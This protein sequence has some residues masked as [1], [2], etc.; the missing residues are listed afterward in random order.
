MAHSNAAAFISEIEDDRISVVSASTSIWGGIDA[1]PINTLRASRKA[2]NVLRRQL[3]SEHARVKSLDVEDFKDE[4]PDVDELRYKFGTEILRHINLARQTAAESQEKA[5]FILPKVA[6]SVATFKEIWDKTSYFGQAAAYPRIDIPTTAEITRPIAEHVAGDKRPRDDLSLS[7]TVMAPGGS[8]GTPRASSPMDPEE[9]EVVEP[10]AMGVDGFRRPGIP[11]RRQRPATPTG[12]ASQALA[13]L[14]AAQPAAQS[15]AQQ[16]ALPVAPTV[17]R[18]V[19][20]WVEQS[21]AATASGGEQ[22]GSAEDP[23]MVESPSRA[24]QL[25]SAQQAQLEEM[26]RQV[27]TVEASL[28]RQY[29]VAV[30]E[31]TKKAAAAATAQQ[32]AELRRVQQ[33][34]HNER[35]Q[36]EAIRR[37]AV[38]QRQQ[39]EQQQQQHQQQQQ[40]QRYEQEQERLLQEQR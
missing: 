20:E 27:A 31:Q 8:V 19:G 11:A 28:R 10:A 40:Q 4:Y 3:T 35:Q 22:A 30:E 24:Q 39:F 12:A 9:I 32:Q 13:A 6:N 34:L 18:S 17:P 29:E 7:T 5:A 38:E 21:A 25:I 16:V 15:T 2:V 1:P 23:V 37:H 26:K 36:S 33:E 14:Q